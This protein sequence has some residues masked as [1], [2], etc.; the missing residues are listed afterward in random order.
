MGVNQSFQAHMFSDLHC[1][2]QAQPRC[3]FPLP[4]V[5]DSLYII[6]GLF[7]SSGRLPLLLSSSRNSYPSS[8][9]VT[10]APFPRFS[11]QVDA[12]PSLGSALAPRLRRLSASEP[13][14]SGWVETPSHWLGTG[15]PRMWKG[16]GMGLSGF[17]LA[18]G[19][20]HYTRL[21]R[22]RTRHSVRRSSQG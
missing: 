13:P 17:G 8:P 20:S 6:L 2:F 4:P 15:S 3:I 18:T 16:S 5:T 9:H 21:R 14:P 1:T 19:S 12:V 10:H 7:L 11:P 22:H